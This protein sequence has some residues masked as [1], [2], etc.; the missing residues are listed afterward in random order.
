MERHDE[1]REGDVPCHPYP[2]SELK[3]RVDTIQ[4]R[5]HTLMTR[6]GNANV[7]MLDAIKLV[8]APYSAK[9]TEQALATAKEKVASDPAF[10]SLDDAAKKKKL[11]TEVAAAQL[12]L[13][14]IE[15]QNN[16]KL[17]E[18]EELQRAAQ[19]RLD[20]VAAENSMGFH[21]P[22]ET[23]RILGESIDLARQAEVRAT[24]L[25][26]ESKN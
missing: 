17:Q 22:Q 16:P 1:L 12:A 6:A 13:W 20:F 4:E 23:A 25:L 26:A 21:A 19:W 9:T 3:E 10:A 5:H 11:D 14:R 8:R 18:L 7:A 24:L 15:V 2:E